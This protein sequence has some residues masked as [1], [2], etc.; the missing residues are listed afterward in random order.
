MY[1]DILN[2]IY[3][4][5]TNTMELIYTN[6]KTIERFQTN[7]TNY[8]NEKRILILMFFIFVMFVMY[9]KKIVFF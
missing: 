7:K 6:N 3:G 1:L 2:T 9:Y 8:T 5:K 4:K